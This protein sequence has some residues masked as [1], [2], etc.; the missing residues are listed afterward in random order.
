[1]NQQKQ[2]LS[3]AS[4]VGFAVVLALF[5]FV[6]V[7]NLNTRTV[8]QVTTPTP[9]VDVAVVPEATPTPEPLV[10]Y[11]ESDVNA[12]RTSFMGTCSACHGP[13]AGGVA[14]LGPDL[15]N[16][17]FTFGLT[18]DEFR[19][20]VITGRGAFHPDNKTRVEMPARGGNPGLSDQSIDQ[21]IAYLRTLGDPSLLLSDDLRPDTSSAETSPEPVVTEEPIIEEAT[22]EPTEEATEEAPAV[23]PTQ[24]TET[25]EPVHL[26][27]S[28]DP[29]AA[30][31]IDYYPYDVLLSETEMYDRIVEAFEMLYPNGI[32]DGILPEAPAVDEESS[33]GFNPYAALPDTSN[34]E[35]PTLPSFGSSTSDD[36]AE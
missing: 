3:S 21:I 6:L 26:Y 36:D 29:W 7:A 16:N 12:G 11:F 5:V 8:Q 22:V 10:G 13:D 17:A 30:P 4:I 32:P 31:L 28:D 35:V 20:F 33:T 23:V 27:A 14:G 15:V 18:D 34:I 19:E 24:Q 25:G 2:S 1:M 9:V